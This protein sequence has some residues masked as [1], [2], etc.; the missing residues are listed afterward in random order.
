MIKKSI[1]GIVL[2][3]CSAS[4]YAQNNQL[5]IIKKIAVKDSTLL[6]TLS[7]IPN[8]FK[9]INGVIPISQDSY[10]I[11]FS[12]TLL[13]WKSKPN[14]DSVM[15]QYQTFPLLFS[16]KQFNKDPKIIEEVVIGKNPFIYT[17]NKEDNSIFNFEGFNKSG[18]ISRGIGFGNNQDL[19][20]N[21]NLVL[22]LSGKLNNEIEI[23]AAISDDNIP[24]QPEG[25][26][27]QIND[28]DKVFIQLKRKGT[29]LIAGD[30][31]LRKPDSY[32]TNYYKRTQG[33]LFSNNFK[34][35][36]GHEFS[37]TFA[38]AVAKG[39]S[40]RNQFDGIEGNQGPYRLQGNNGEQ[41]II[42]LSGTERVYIDGVLLLRGQDNDYVMDYNTSELTFTSKRL[43]TR[44]SRIVVE[45]EY[46]DKVFARSLYNLNQG[47][48]SEKLKIGFNYY[49][50]QDNANRPLIQS[51]SDP[52]KQFL[53]GIGNNINQA[54]FPNADSV[55]FSQNEILYKKIDTLGAQGVYV[56]NTNPLL[57]KFRVGFTFVGANLGNYRINT[58][59]EANGRVYVFNASINGVLQGDYEPVTLLVTPKKQQLITLNADYKI[60]KKTNIFTEVGYSDNDVNLYSNIGNA[61]N[62]GVAYKLIFQ[63]QR[64]FK[65]NDTTGLKLKSNL[66]YEYLNQ[67]FKPLERYRPVEFDRDFNFRGT[68]LVPADEH[69]T[70]LNFKL[71]KNDLKQINYTFSNFNRGSSYNGIQ[72]A[73]AS[74]YHYKKYRLFYAG[75]LLN[76]K[77][78][79]EDGAF[80][81]NNL[82][83][84]KVFKVNEAGLAYRAE[85]NQPNNLS[86]NQ[87][88]LQ[89][90][91]FREYEAYF[92]SADT[93]KTSFLLLYNQRFDDLPLGQT[94]I[95]FSKAITVSGKLL[96]SKT[97]NS[98]LSINASYRTL[99]YLNNDTLKQNEETLLGRVDYNFTSLKG[100]INLQSFYELGTGQEP[101][102]EF[103]YL[104]VAAAQGIY[105][106]ND[107]NSNGIKELNEFEISRFPDQARYIK[108]FRPN[109]QFV[110]SNFTN[111]NQTLTLNPAIILKNRKEKVPVFISKFSN[112]TSLRIDKKVL[113]GESVLFNPY[114]TSINESNL[115]ALNSFIRNTLF[116]NRSNPVFG[117]DVSLQKLGSKLLLTN[118]FDSRNNQEKSLRIRWNFI[119]KS[120][121]NISFNNGVKDFSSQLFTERNYHINYYE[122][123]PEFGYQF[124]T[125]FKTTFLINL[126]NQKNDVVFGGEKTL[127]AKIGSEL[128]Y[129]ILKK[130][131]ITSQFN[132]INNSFEGKNNTS[133]AY[134]LLDGLQPGKNLTW[135][136]G[137]QTTIANGIQ[138]NFTYEG[139]K[140]NDVRTIH[141]GGLQF[142][143]YF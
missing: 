98:N 3:I 26:T 64:N 114:Q 70:T 12:S 138:L 4:V 65:G 75:S 68:V 48:K 88:S 43:I 107:Y 80:Y 113:A 140:S 51:L 84:S 105:S 39:R 34:D 125:D 2:L 35:K 136:A 58:S 22:Q 109:N 78:T 57:A 47:F 93:A 134:E 59:S 90:F 120:N 106:W 25:N 29:T 82:A 97:S 123:Q 72:Q 33:A 135:S 116:F 31:E 10:Q 141:T 99:K 117:F 67:Q 73:L 54:V 76:S 115:I 24:I 81:K 50:E 61:Q 38:A 36:N 79:V 44:N 101:K 130:G 129:N 55:A 124:S 128:R 56:Y 13:I 63:D 20:V 71:F 27:Q 77:T 60:G 131:T 7:I 142:R 83:V 23:L 6:D 85:N 1:I 49:S 37:T 16:K 69:W 102:R 94:L 133:V 5:A 137:F 11:N 122:L 86:T 45:F 66:S 103:V 127:N 15:V 119:R 30:Y 19:A 53:S 132:F 74:V 46:S 104:E 62:K 40:A 32:F 8:T 52:Q 89:S 28:F 110:R 112:I 91:A 108:I 139:R 95:A 100:F 118:G 126:K 87:L 17:A 96:I 143:A 9:L 14:T 92:K 41:F 111:I 121:F 18:S 42:V 21:S